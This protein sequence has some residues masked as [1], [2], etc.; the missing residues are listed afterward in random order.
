MYG[1]RTA[2]PTLL[3]FLLT[4]AGCHGAVLDPVQPEWRPCQ[5]NRGEFP[6]DGCALLDGTLVT[7]RSEPAASFVVTVDSVDEESR[8][9]FTAPPAPVPADG[10]LRILVTQI[11]PLGS[12]PVAA[13]VVRTLEVRVYSTIDD[14]RARRA[15]RLSV[16]V[17]MVFTPWGVLVEPTP[18]RLAIPDV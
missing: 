4:A 5:P 11:R 1:M 17:P 6:P 7:P 12:E 9:W 14:A 2:G 3:V 16:F 8:S 13:R 18:V 10:S 15:P